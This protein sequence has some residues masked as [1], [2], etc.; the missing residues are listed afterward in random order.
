M[1]ETTD[2]LD[3]RMPRLLLGVVS[4]HSGVP[5][6]EGLSRNLP[7]KV[8]QM[9]EVLVHKFMKALEYR[10]KREHTLVR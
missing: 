8:T 7:Q 10:K 2:K 4:V 6:S 1:K 5:W 3:M 9:D